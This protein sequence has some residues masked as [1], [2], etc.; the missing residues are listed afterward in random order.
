YRLIWPASVR[1]A[2]PPRGPAPGAPVWV[3]ADPAQPPIS[4]AASAGRQLLDARVQLAL[5]PGGLVAMDQAL[6]HGR[7]DH[8]AGDLELGGRIFLV[9]CFHGAHDAFD[10]GTQLGPGGHVVRTALDRLTGSLLS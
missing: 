4:S 6:V 3:L 7:V 10:G 9:A 5:V 8:G 2:Y 1:Q